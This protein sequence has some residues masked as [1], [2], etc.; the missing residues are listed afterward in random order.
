METI[1][2]GKNYIKNFKIEQQLNKYKRV[3]KCNSLIAIVGTKLRQL[4]FFFPIIK[5]FAIIAK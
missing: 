3:D 5:S 2:D 1:M 4:V